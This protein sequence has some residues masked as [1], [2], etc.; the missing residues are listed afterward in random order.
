M[1]LSAQAG[2]LRRPGSVRGPGFTLLE[3]ILGLTIMAILLGAM[4]ASIAIATRCVDDQSG[5]AAQTM[6]AA[7]ALEEINADLSLA[8][9]FTERTPGAVTF[10]VPDRN[11]DGADETLRY[12][13]SGPPEYQLT[14]QYNGGPAVVV[15]EDAQHFN[16]AYG[17]KT[18]TPPPE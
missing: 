4:V 17:L 1:R 11:G 13:W 16:L 14:R 3:M 6:T 10:V 9:R 2:R 7:G 12:A 18:V 8:L 15:A 5:P